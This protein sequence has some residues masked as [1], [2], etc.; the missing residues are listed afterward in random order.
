[1]SPGP[2]QFLSLSFT[3]SLT[4]SV[5]LCS[6]AKMD[7][8]NRIFLLPKNLIPW[9]LKNLVLANP[10]PPPHTHTW[11][12]TYRLTFTYDQERGTSTPGSVWRWIHTST[13]PRWTFLGWCVKSGVARCSRS[14]ETHWATACRLDRWRDLPSS[15]LQ[16]QTT[17]DTN[18]VAF[19]SNRNEK[20]WLNPLTR[21]Q[22]WV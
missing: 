20:D 19:C 11:T 8:K 12:Y 21:E 5:C 22:A 2:S 7:L 6:L 15:R 1:M 17:H 9:V 3:L 10:P 16:T 13:R 4:L 14:T 18:P